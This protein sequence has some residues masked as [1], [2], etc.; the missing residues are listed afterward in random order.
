MDYYAGLDSLEASDRVDNLRELVSSAASRP[1]GAEGLCALLEEAALEGGTADPFSA[2][3][4]V[5]LITLHNTKGLEFDRVVI[6][7]LE[8]GVFPLVREGESDIEEE[9][10]LLYVGITRARSV[11]YLLSCRRR[12]LYGRWRELEPSRLLAEIPEESIQ[13]VGGSTAGADGGPPRE[14]EQPEITEGSTVYH[15]E[16]GPGVVQSRWVAEGNSGG[17]AMV[18]VRF[19]TGRSV[20]FVLR[21]SG[22]ERI[23]PPDP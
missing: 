19:Q 5:T 18:L 1:P 4:K 14:Q 11:L 15:Q 23:A 13:R 22:L 7:G 6:T 9:R 12:R 21:F 20:K 2:E 17:H 10:R 8:E 16:Y 3:R